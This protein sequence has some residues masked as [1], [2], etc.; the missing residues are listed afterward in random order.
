MK[1]LYFEVTLKTDIILNQK[2]ASE[3]PNETLDFIPGNNFLGIVAGAIYKQSTSAGGK[4]PV[5][6]MDLFHNSQVRFGDAHLV[7]GTGARSLKVPAAMYYPKKSSPD[8]ETY[9]FHCTEGSTFRKEQLKQCRNG[10]YDFTAADKVAVPCDVRTNF[11]IKSAHD[12]VQRTSK[13]EKMYGYESLQAGA[14]MLFS[15][16]VEKE[17]LCQKIIDAL[18]DTKTA[19]RV[20]RSRT[21]QYGLVEITQVADTQYKEVKS[22]SVS[23]LVTVYADSRLIFINE[24]TGLPTFQ[25]SVKHLGFD[26]GVINWEKSQVRT[27]QYTPW[28]FKRQC[29][30]T[31]RCGIEKGSV[32]V[33]EEVT[34]CPNESKYVGNYNNEGFGKVIYN[35]DFLEA[36][37]DGKTK[38]ALKAKESKEDSKSSESKQK[39][40]CST[41]T[42]PLIANLMAQHNEAIEELEIFKIV[43]EWIRDN[44]RLFKG[45]SFASQWGT[46]RSIATRQLI[47]G[48]TP[49][50][51]YNALFREDKNNKNNSGYL[52]HGIAEHSWEERGRMS[53]LKNFFKYKMENMSDDKKC[54]V[55]IN[56][57]AEMAKKCS[58]NEQN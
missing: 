30:D 41:A 33:I 26:S 11:A 18:T 44:V 2:A 47:D 53:Q 57:A 8:K 36:E 3:G 15:V 10:F 24:E 22:K 56:L 54:L 6:A 29:F 48:N 37:P 27:F 55:I 23:G 19:K 58:N 1:T 39:F 7:S 31:D 38:W 34:D 20:G 16:E 43:N 42:S 32:I 5:E 28:N 52:M 12:R 40:D 50:S 46:I 14:K 17:E 21:A 4:Y 49:E 45:K 35:P 25:P 9:I 51:L 13:D